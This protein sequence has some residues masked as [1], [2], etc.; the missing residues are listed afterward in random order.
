[1]P[2]KVSL[3]ENDS[4]IIIESDGQLRRRDTSW[5]AERVGE[6]LGQNTVAGI[7]ADSTLVQKQTSVALSGE[8]ISG[9]VHAITSDIPVAFVRPTCWSEDYLAQIRGAMEDMPENSR[10][11]D[12]TSA[13]RD[14]LRDEISGRL[15]AV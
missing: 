2:V 6:L 11:F 4:I 10:I 5:G 8:M 7:L 12:E 15:A 3:G 14:W 1:M 9:F 13:A